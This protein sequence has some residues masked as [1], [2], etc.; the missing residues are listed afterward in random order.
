MPLRPDRDPALTSCA[1]TFRADASGARGGPAAVS[2]PNLL[3]QLRRAP[4]EC[5]QPQRPVRSASEPLD[6]AGL[7][8][9]RRHGFGIS[10]QRPRVLAGADIVLARVACR[11][12]G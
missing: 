1:R 11:W 2:D 9:L 12:Q 10:I 6:V 4:P 8:T 3:R 7:G 5:I